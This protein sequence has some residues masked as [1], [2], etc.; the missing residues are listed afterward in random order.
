M[1][2]HSDAG[3]DRI[4]VIGITP[5]LNTL[6]IR[7]LRGIGAICLI[8]VYLPDETGKRWPSTAVT[9]QNVAI[10]SAGYEWIR[11]HSNLK[12]GTQPI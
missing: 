2:F 11:D 7:A 1:V 4:N 8:V 3:K 9:N 10:V 12:I 5:H 6:L